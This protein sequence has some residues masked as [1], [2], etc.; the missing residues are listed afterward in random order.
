MANTL[1]L[2]VFSYLVLLFI[3]FLCNSDK[4]KFLQVRDE[5]VNTLCEI[6]RHVGEKVRQDL[7]KKGIPGQK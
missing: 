2:L 1:Y 5:T 6:Y 4:I 3:P 7:A